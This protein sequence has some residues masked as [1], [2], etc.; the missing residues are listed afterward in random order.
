MNEELLAT[1]DLFDRSG[2][3]LVSHNGFINF[4]QLSNLKLTQICSAS[5]ARQVITATLAKT[6]REL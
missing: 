3:L 1:S 4:L 6:H 5:A 2:A